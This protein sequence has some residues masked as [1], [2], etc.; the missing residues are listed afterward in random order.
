MKDRE[1]RIEGVSSLYLGMVCLSPDSKS[2][3]TATTR[4]RY[5]V[6]RSRRPIIEF[7]REE[8]LNKETSNVKTTD[9]PDQ[10]TN[11]KKWRLLQ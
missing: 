8:R 5:I 7:V 9:G 11:R 3:A 4:G 1:S 2:P 10:K 6:V